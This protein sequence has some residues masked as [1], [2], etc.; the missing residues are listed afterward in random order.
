MS[1]RTSGRLKHTFVAAI[2]LSPTF[3]L[4]K[5]CAQVGHAPE[6]S[7]YRSLQATKW[8]SFTGGYLN[9]SAGS[10]EVGPTDGPLAGLQASI[11][12]GG[13]ADAFLDLSV[14]R[15]RRTLIHRDSVPETR[16]IGTADQTLLFADVGANLLL[17]GQKTW[18][19]LIPYV[20]GN[21]GL[22]FGS[23]VKQDISGFRFAIQFHTGPQVGIRLHPSDRISLRVEARDVI[24]RLSYPLA[25]LEAPAPDIPPVLDPEIHDKSEWTHHLVL[26]FGLAFALGS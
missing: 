7:P 16:T 2:L 22:V 5:L 15:L 1:N 12:M 3:G 24:W 18:H 10:A 17:T 9:G 26:M 8:L 6:S 13:P 20:G 23:D 21:L 14:A 19:G 25:F 4:G 11:K